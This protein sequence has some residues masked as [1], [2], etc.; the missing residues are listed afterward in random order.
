MLGHIPK[1][2]AMQ[3]SPSNLSRAKNP[4]VLLQP[5]RGRVEDGRERGETALTMFL[6]QQSSKRN[7][8]LHFI[9]EVF[10]ENTVIQIP[11]F[12]TFLTLYW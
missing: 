7:I 8:P 12:K 1:Q 10:I 11:V 3:D 2:G 6:V 9:K 5:R 4:M